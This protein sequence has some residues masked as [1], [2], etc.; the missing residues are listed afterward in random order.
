VRTL[1]D[2]GNDLSNVFKRSFDIRFAGSEGLDTISSGW[3]KIQAQI[4]TTNA[5]IKKYQDTMQQLTADKAVTE[6]WLKVAQNYGD[7]LRASELQ[8]QLAKQNSDLASN[9][10]SLSDAQSKNSMTLDGNSQAAIQNRATI[11]GLV[12]N[13]EDYIAKLAA[14]GASQ[15]TL[16]AESARLKQDF[17]SQATQL[18]FNG[19]QLKQY[20]AAFDDVTTAVNRVPRNITVTGSAYPAIQA[21]NELEARAKQVANNVGGAGYDAGTGF[22]QNF[23]DG[24]KQWL[25]KTPILVQGYTVNSGGQP[26]YQIPGTQTKLFSDGG[27]TGDGGKYDPAGIVHAGEFVFSQDAVRNI[28]VENLA[29]MHNMA[30]GGGLGGGSSAGGGGTVVVELSPF[31]RQLLADAGN[32]HVSI[33]GVAIAKAV[34]QNNTS[35]AARRAA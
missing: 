5:D 10:Q 29:F 20:A 21:L 13:Y 19:D 18:G 16:R 1:V 33:P 7:T 8:A 34:S 17:I 31:D 3:Q 23:A 12:G 27:Y 35:T 2:Y 22:A 15:E 6:Y 24:M 26:V 28:G 14:S 25:L 32:L 9:T 4:A 11:L 30:K